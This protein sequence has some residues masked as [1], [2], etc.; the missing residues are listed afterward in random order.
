MSYVGLS[1]S[2]T[3]R[4]SFTMLCPTLTFPRPSPSPHP[5]LYPVLPLHP[6]L[7]GLRSLPRPVHRGAG[8]CPEEQS[9]VWIRPRMVPGHDASDIRAVVL[10]RDSTACLM[11]LTLSLSGN[12]SVST[13]S[14]S[15]SLVGACFILSCPVLSCQR[16]SYRNTSRNLPDV[17]AMHRCKSR[18]YYCSSAMHHMRVS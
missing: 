16:H 5:D 10:V 9:N 1:T 14:Q 15:I 8:S 3:A 4:N 13:V 18:C 12:L 2:A 17:A 11:C 7:S 6:V